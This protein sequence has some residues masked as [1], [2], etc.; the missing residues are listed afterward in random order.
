MK[1]VEFNHV[2]VFVMLKEPLGGPGGDRREKWSMRLV[3]QRGLA[4]SK[5]LLTTQ[6]FRFLSRSL[7][8][9]DFHILFREDLS[10]NPLTKWRLFYRLVSKGLLLLYMLINIFMRGTKKPSSRMRL[11]KKLFRS[12]RIPPN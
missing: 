5:G 8:L 4:K 1:L 7:S 6:L 11:Q 9:V 3:F 2:S 10:Q 12:E